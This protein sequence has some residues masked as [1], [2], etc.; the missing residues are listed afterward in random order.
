MRQAKLTASQ[1]LRIVVL[2]L[3]L[4]FFFFDF[5]PQCSNIKSVGDLIPS[6]GIE[7]DS[8]EFKTIVVDQVCEGSVR[9]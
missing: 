5:I 6:L 4:F 8:L 1:N 7:F 2:V 9:V 3:G